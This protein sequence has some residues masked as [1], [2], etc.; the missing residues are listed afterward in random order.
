VLAGAEPTVAS[1]PLKDNGEDEILAA[2]REVENRRGWEKG[3]GEGRK[4]KRKGGTVALLGI[5][6][7]GKSS[8]LEAVKL[9]FERRGYRCSA[10][11]FH[12]YIVLDSLAGR[13]RGDLVSRG[14]RGRG[15]PMRPLASLV[16]NLALH[17]LTAFGVGVRGVVVVYDRYI[18]STYIKYKALGYPVGPLS[19]LYLLP[20]PTFAVVLDIPVSR[21][22]E[23]IHSRPTHIRYQASVLSQEREEYLRIASARG[24]PV[25][26]TTASFSEVQAEIE[27][28]LSR[29]FPSRSTGVDWG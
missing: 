29:V 23:V 15:N 16:D 19:K 9:W 2:L 20:R 24:Y 26:D 28:Q 7:S 22:L 6:G 3:N 13:P 14:A 10:V 27:R 5:D 12:K 18:W 1:A 17:T 25:I 11:Q 21:S 4:G 8:H